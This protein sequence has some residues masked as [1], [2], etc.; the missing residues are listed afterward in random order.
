MFIE[1]V[2]DTRSWVVDIV[3][4]LTFGLRETWDGKKVN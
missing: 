2:V 4:I 1:M 3:Y